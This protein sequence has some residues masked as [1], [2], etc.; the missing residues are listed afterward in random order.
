[1]SWKYSTASSYVPRDSASTRES[2]QAKHFL[3]SKLS[4]TG[5]DARRSGW[6]SSNISTDS[7]KFHRNLIESV[8]H[9]PVWSRTNT[10]E[11]PASVQRLKERYNLTDDHIKSRDTKD[12]TGHKPQKF[13]G[14]SYTSLHVDDRTTPETNSNYSKF[15]RKLDKSPE[16]EKN[17][18]GLNKFSTNLRP[19]EPSK[20][21]FKPSETSRLPIRTNSNDSS[22]NSLHSVNRSPVITDTPDSPDIVVTVVTRGTS[23]TPTVS[24]VYLRTKRSDFGIEKRITRPRKKPEMVHKEIQ[25]DKEALSYSKY[26]VYGDCN[27]RTTPWSPYSDKYS[28]G[29]SYNSKYTSRTGY[30]SLGTDYRSISR[31]DSENATTPE[32]PLKSPIGKPPFVKEDKKPYVRKSPPSNFR[33]PLKHDGGKTEGSKSPNSPHY[34]TSP[35]QCKV[36]TTELPRSVCKM[37]GNQSPKVTIDRCPDLMQAIADVS[38]ASESSEEESTSEDDSDQQ[39]AS[40]AMTIKKSITNFLQNIPNGPVQSQTRSNLLQK[41]NTSQKIN[42]RRIESGE[43]AWWMDSNDK[44][45][46]GVH[47]IKSTR[48]VPSPEYQEPKSASG[49][50]Y[51]SPTFSSGRFLGLS[52]DRSRS[53][54]EDEKESRSPR[55]EKPQHMEEFNGY[56]NGDQSGSLQNTYCPLNNFPTDGDSMKFNL[57]VEQTFNDSGRRYLGDFPRE[58][59]AKE[60][61]QKLT[62]GLGS[63]AEDKNHLDP[64]GMSGLISKAKAELNKAKP[65]IRKSSSR[66]MSP[67]VTDPKSEIDL[68][69]KELADSVTRPLHLCDLDFTDLNSDDETDILGTTKM[70][71]EV[72]VPPPMLILPMPP[73]S[74]Q[75]K[76]PG[77]PAPPAFNQTSM[78]NF[79]VPPPPAPPMIVK[80]KKTVKLFWKEVKD[81]SAMVKAKVPDVGLIWDE[82]TKVKIDTQKLE[83][84]FESRA[85]D[86]SSKKQQDQIK[87]KE[88]IVLDPKRSNA[89][90]IGMTKLPPPRAIKTAILKMDSTV[91]NKE[92]IEKVLTMLPTEEEKVRIQEAQS[93]NPDVPLG[94]AEQ[95]LLTLASISQL[96]ARLRLWAFKLD[97]EISE[98]EICEPLMD[99]KQG[100]EILRVNNTFRGIL[101]TLLSVGNFLNGCDAKGFQIEYLSKVP[102]VKDTVHKHSLLHHLCIIVMEKFPD[103]TDLYSEIGAVTRASKVDFDEL[104]GNI[105]KLEDECKL[106][107]NYLKIIAKHEGHTAMKVRMSDFLADCAERIIVLGIVHKRI[108][109][110]FQ[111]FAYWLGVPMNRISTTRPN[112]IFKIISEFAL[113]FRTTRDRVLQQIKKINREKNR[114]RGYLALDA[115]DSIGVKMNS[116]EA[117]DDAKL[118]QLLGKDISYNENMNIPTWRRHRKDTSKQSQMADTILP[119]LPVPSE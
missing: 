115:N 96:E 85:K 63:P 13:Y 14:R 36:T 26:S 108:L 116:K 11:N 30:N 2:T 82:L 20:T 34:P 109:S 12:V 53:T 56:T 71:G 15:R 65:D 74:V 43:K 62:N 54:F 101:S 73:T 64:N 94:S 39:P 107:W 42:F 69:W 4:S 68:Y 8:E 78:R 92:G 1:M 110:R 88:I 83:N 66:E 28:T 55:E 111:K 104:A 90:N 35:L 37:G 40:C 51:L 17:T 99:L 31:D 46:E 59:S 93:A 76:P 100:M 57:Q 33:L 58:C 97:F 21:L 27:V 72:P 41:T 60:A 102:E 45:P 84:L 119:V 95:F 113:E 52:N 87:N 105:K 86:L 70:N 89:I 61:S 75:L 80:N 81:E 3:N 67:M 48:S 7:G 6:S 117:K 49:N 19:L 77:A 22:P 114:S 29:N 47:K 16:I 106:S 9:S 32:S 23:P 118:K 18:Y 79:K 25:T 50:N 112:E 44:V 98:K 10:A 38:S 5:L 91:V 24:A 103:S